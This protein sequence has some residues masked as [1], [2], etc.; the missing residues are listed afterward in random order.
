M[1]VFWRRLVALF[2]RDSIDRE[3]DEELQFHL[4][5]K[6][7]DSGDRFA[8]QRALG[9]SLLLRERARDAWGWRFLDELAQDIRYALRGMRRS[10]GFALAAILTLALA[11]GANCLVF[12]VADATLF[13]PF[14]FRDPDRL[15]YI[16]SKQAQA[17]HWFSSTGNYLDWRARNTV[18]EDLGAYGTYGYMSLSQG[19]YSERIY[20]TH[21]SA[22]FFHLAGIEA[23]LG[24]T[25]LPEEERSAHARVI[26]L[27][28]HLWRTRFGANP[29]IIGSTVSGVHYDNSSIV[30]TVIGV[31]PA[32]IEQTLRFEDFWTPLLRDDADARS[33]GGGGL[34]VVGRLKPGVSLAAARASMQALVENLRPAHPR[35]NRDLGVSITSY[36]DELTR[37][38]RPQTLLL[39]AAV[40]LVLLIACVNVA[41]LMLARGAERIHELSIRSAVGA[42]RRRLFRQLLTESLALGLIGGCLGIVLAYA[43]V[44]AVRALLPT[45]TLR[46]DTVAV[47][48]KVLL[49]TLLVSLATGLLFGLLPAF[50]ASKLASQAKLQPHEQTL[51]R[52]VLI[53]AEIALALILVTGA[54]LMVN[55]FARLLSKDLGF[56][57]RDL[58]AVD[59]NLPGTKFKT[60]ADR[61]PIQQ[62][63]R[64]RLGSLPGV[65]A[66][67]IGESSPLGSIATLDFRA[68]LNAGLQNDEPQRAWTESVTPEYFETMGTPVLR[69][70]AFTPQDDS[71]ARQVVIVNQAFARRFWPG[72]DPLGK[73][74]WY[75]AGKD[76]IPS[77][78][79]GVVGNSIGMRLAESDSMVVYFSQ[80]Q[81][82][83]STILAILIRLEPGLPPASLV[84]AIRVELAAID[85]SLAVESARP[86]QSYIDAQLAE[87]RFLTIILAIFAALALGLTVTGI[88]GVIA[89]LV[90]ARTFE[91]GVR[92]ALGAQPRDI[93]SLICGYGGRLAAA[94]IVLGIGGSLALTR[95]LATYLYGVKPRRSSHSR[96][97][98][99]PRPTRRH[100]RLLRPRPPSPAHRPRPSLTS[101]LDPRKTGILSPVPAARPAVFGSAPG[102][103]QAIVSPLSAPRSTLSYTPSPPTASTLV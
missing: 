24:R 20:G 75:Q 96:H 26:L 48:G 78:V 77:D 14:A 99:R 81:R 53:V 97:R 52:G 84:P 103:G 50:R 66:V 27:S 74:I 85:P 19:S 2:R 39:L 58:L 33:W 101:R 23:Q 64:E 59:A 90:R 22:S 91:F 38:S 1:K 18:F 10:P 41:N 67:S 80:A 92:M 55:S 51:W 34:S 94:G 72:E 83:A 35:S 57:R 17:D 100:A 61:L 56:D 68:S 98:R 65:R 31:L 63:V 71:S 3:L 25:F 44:G 47:N 36:H 54:G 7:H 88:L 28:D 16:W 8:A 15:V 102:A 79:V 43:S 12:S 60:I 93:L 89:Y 4:A 37:N 95:L 6:A 30:Y 49:V 32:A 76:Q 21:A 42:G 87:P 9:N 69:G 45:W 70:R 29:S 13:R 46:R 40:T 86:M 62:L 82:I 5:A 11:I 73:T